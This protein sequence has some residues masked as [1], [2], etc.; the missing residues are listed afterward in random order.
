MSRP[1]A[2]SPARRARWLP[3]AAV[4]LAALA[5]RCALALVSEGYSSDVACFSAWALRL[6]ENGPGAFYAPDYFA[7][8]PPGYMLLLWPV[9]LIARALQLEAG[10]KAM[11]FLICLW[12]IL[13]DLGLSALIWSI[14][15]RFFGRGVDPDDLY[16]L[17]C[18]GFL[19]AIDGFDLQYGTQF[20]TYA[21]PKI[22]GEIRRFLRDDGSVKVSRGIKER[23]MA[24]RQCRQDLY[25]RLGR[26]PTVGEL[27]QAT[28]LEPEDIAAAETATLSVASLQSQTGEDGFTL[29]S[30]LGCTGMEEEV[31]ERLALRQAID[32]LP[33]RERKVILLRFYK[34]L[35][36]E[37]TAR[38]L[39]VSQVQISRMERR[40][41][42]HLREWLTEESLPT[43]VG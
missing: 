37:R 39:G 15:R 14:A 42:G 30:M 8:Y 35:T 6:A 7:D 16:Q 27:A 33:D 5:V 9:G 13:C 24:L 22:A 34:N 12:P 31:V 2:F 18:L 29:E 17:G 3:L 32:A 28:G 4:L 11:S 1:S 21:V 43:T 36:Q 26:D 25:H 40:A 38:I 19:K 10:G 23:A 41:I 20:S